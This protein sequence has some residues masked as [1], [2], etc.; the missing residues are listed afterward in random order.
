MNDFFYAEEMGGVPACH[1]DS[2]NDLEKECRKEG[3]EARVS[4]FDSERF[5]L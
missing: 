4:S 5:Y 1:I 3:F 2:M